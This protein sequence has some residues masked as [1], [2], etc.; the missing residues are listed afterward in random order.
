MPGIAGRQRMA[1]EIPKTAY[2][3]KIKEVTLGVGPRAVTV[4]GETSYPFYLF[5]GKMP[6][7]PKIA[8]EVWDI[9]PEDW[10][11]AALEPFGGV[12]NDPI[13]WAKKCINEYK[14][15]MI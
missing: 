11:E 6:H 9:Q 4:G 3:G 7:Q 8:M 15:E 13:E 14:A 1:V 2:T 10:P 12:I 5:E